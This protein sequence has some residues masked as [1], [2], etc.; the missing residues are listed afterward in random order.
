MRA[1]ETLARTAE[2]TRDVHS[3]REERAEGREE[4]RRGEMERRGEAERRG[5]TERRGE[6]ERRGVGGERRRLMAYESWRHKLKDQMARLHAK[7][8]S[9]DEKRK[10][11]RRANSEKMQLD[12]RIDESDI[13]WEA[14][15]LPKSVMDKAR[16]VV[17]SCHG[18]GMVVS[19]PVPTW[20]AYACDAT[21]DELLRYLDYEPRRMCPD[22]WFDSQDL[23]FTKNCFALPVRHCLTRTP[24]KLVEPTPFPESLFSQS[25]L[26]NGAV[27][28]A[29]HHCKSFACLNARLIGDCRLC[30]NMSIE[31][32]RWHRH[33]RGSLSIEEVVGMMKGSLRIGLDAGGGTGSFAAHMARYNVT[34]L[35]TAMNIETVTGR[36]QGLPYM[37][38]IALRG[39][40]PLHVPH[41]GL[42]YM[43]TIAL[44]GLIPLHVSH[45]GVATAT[46]DGQ[47]VGPGALCEQ[48]QVKVPLLAPSPP[49]VPSSPHLTDYPLQQRLPLM[50]NTLDLVHCV[51]G[52]NYLP[53]PC[54]SFE[55]TQKAPLPAPSPPPSPLPQQ[56]LPL[57]D[58]TLDL[59]HCVNSIKYLP[60]QEFEE[61][62]FDWDRVLRVGGVLWFEMFYAPLDEMPVYVALISALG[63]KRLYYHVLPKPD[64]GEQLGAHMY[65]NCLL[66]KPVRLD[67]PKRTGWLF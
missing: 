2:G 44:R 21:E 18:D 14:R 3:E 8:T 45:K 22:D 47:H 30:F 35:T 62:L 16:E 51:S 28:W 27:R 60:M 7:G 23:L 46:P 34:V 20:K 56:R 66:E 67:P 48:H 32:N 54:R 12:K 33:F 4:D 41:K 58:N 38:T 52:I 40:I 9:V 65:L 57:L 61:L 29:L 15:L 17:A 5:E 1:A 10:E 49:P 37:E 26:K 24:Q 59:V 19:S 50:D 31:R 6:M 13:D 42:P 11:L 63:Y 43:E 53:C 36:R 39:L 25:A 55:S 64:V